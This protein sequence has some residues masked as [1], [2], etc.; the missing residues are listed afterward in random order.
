LRAV[1]IGLVIRLI[2]SFIEALGWDFIREQFNINILKPL[3]IIGM[4][5]GI[6]IVISIP[7]FILLWLSEI[8]KKWREKRKEKEESKKS[9]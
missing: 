3:K 7:I 6:L 4:F 8:E 9:D 2:Y 5:L 1:G